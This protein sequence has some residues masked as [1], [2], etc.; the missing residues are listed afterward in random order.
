ME[1]TSIN[2]TK[3]TKAENDCKKHVDAILHSNSIKKVVV[4]GPGTGKTYLFS[5][6]LQDKEKTLT[7]TFIN[8][9]VEDLSLELCGISEVKTLHGFARSILKQIIGNDIKISQ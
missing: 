5:K 2:E 7:L 6:I 4:A 9:L 1:I 8:S 3:Y